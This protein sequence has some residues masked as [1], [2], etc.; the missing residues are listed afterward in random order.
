M[1]NFAMSL[2]FIF[3]ACVTKRVMIFFPGNKFGIG[4][5]LTLVRFYMDIQLLTI[6]NT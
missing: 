4:N 6:I 3:S 1:P 2:E 5:Y